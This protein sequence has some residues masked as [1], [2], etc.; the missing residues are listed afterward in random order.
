MK[1]RIGTFGAA[2]E[3]WR[4]G[5]HSSASVDPHLINHVSSAA[6][7][8]CGAAA[9]QIGGARY[10]QVGPHILMLSILMHI[11]NRG[12]CAEVRSNASGSVH[13]K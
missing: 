11:S 7:S 4:I 6:A 2:A 10:T 9:A 13:V 12:R 1:V 5:R 8:D 3:V